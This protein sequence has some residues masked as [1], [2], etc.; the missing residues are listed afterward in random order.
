MQPE[1]GNRWRENA[2]FV[3]LL[4]EFH[5]RVRIRY[6]GG[7]KTAPTKKRKNTL[8]LQIAVKPYKIHF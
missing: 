5:Q 8:W 7:P 3:F 6:T 2:F 4:R 1:Q